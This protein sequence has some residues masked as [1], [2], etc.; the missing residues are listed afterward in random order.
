MWRDCEMEVVRMV[1]HQPAEKST[2]QKGS[3]TPNWTPSSDVR[4]QQHEYILCRDR[5]SKSIEFSVDFQT[6][7]MGKTS[8]SSELEKKIYESRATL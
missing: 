1:S 5:F 4:L 8:S 3:T 2:N 6:F 7:S